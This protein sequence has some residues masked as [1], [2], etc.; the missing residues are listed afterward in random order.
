M[1]SWDR[2]LESY[3]W[4]HNACQSGLPA[5]GVRAVFIWMAPRRPCRDPW[6][7]AE[8]RGDCG[9]GQACRGIRRRPHVVTRTRPCQPPLPVQPSNRPHGSRL[10]D[11]GL[12]VPQAMHILT[13]ATRPLALVALVVPTHAR[14]ARQT[15][16]YQSAVAPLQSPYAAGLAADRTASNNAANNAAAPKPSAHGRPRMPSICLGLTC[17]ACQNPAP[18]SRP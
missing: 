8:R 6:Q 5:L 16:D 3:Q 10:S 11:A 14:H 18:T 15:T 12:L 7:A 1:I 2:F 13:R 9:R 17:R 4:S